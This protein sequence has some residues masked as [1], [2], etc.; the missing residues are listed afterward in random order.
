[1]HACIQMICFA[2]G[3]FSLEMNDV[4]SMNERMVIE[5]MK[6]REEERE[7]SDHKFSLNV[8]TVR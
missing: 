5:R 7:E 6:R 3:V 2:I 1:M 8:D 4:T